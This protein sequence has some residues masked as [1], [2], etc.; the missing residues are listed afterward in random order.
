MA[1]L[2]GAA[3]ASRII[4]AAPITLAEI[5]ARFAGKIEDREAVTFDAASASL[6]A[7]R[8]RRLGAVVLAEQ[9]K[10]VAPDAETARILA[11]GIVGLGLDKLPWSKAALQ[12]RNRVLFLRRA[13]GD[14][15]PDL[16]DEGLARSAAEW[17]EPLL[18][19]KTARSEIS[20]DELSD[21][22]TALLPWALRKR[23]DAEAPTH[24]TAP[25]G[26]HVPIDYEAEEGP[27]LSIRV[28]ELFGLAAAS[29]HRRRPRAA[30]DRT[31]VAGAP[32]GAGDARSARL[33]ARQ[34]CGRE[35]R[36]A[37]PL[38]QPSLAGRSAVGARDPP[39]Q[40]PRRIK[41]SALA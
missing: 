28:Q 31:A 21:A 16:S 25:S 14:E 10:Q 26:S 11:Q 15:W 17:L 5:E 40:A 7:R 4:L 32:A 24:F 3:A 8:S 41:F 23:L 37:R 29:D 39:R 20:A 2:T 34:L 33:L 13:E 6:R 9:I 12:L 19:D 30:G 36:D 22:I 1:E 38:S 35:S 18:L 27:K